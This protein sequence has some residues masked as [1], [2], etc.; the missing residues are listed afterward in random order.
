MRTL[1]ILTLSFLVACSTTAPAQPEAPKDET[2]TAETTTTDE[3]KPD[4]M[5]G[6]AEGD[7]AGGE[8][9]GEEAAMDLPSVAKLEE[10][11]GLARAMMP[12]QAL[13]DAVKPVL[14]EPTEVTDSEAHWMA[15]DGDDCKMLKVSLMGDMVGSATVEDA[16]CPGGGA[17]E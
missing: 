8:A 2:T 16:E 5:E 15:K 13:M 4:E 1:T 10:A 14:G 3:A 9:D 11:K 6:S 7:A 12:K 17:A